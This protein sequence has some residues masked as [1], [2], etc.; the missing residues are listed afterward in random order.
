M[1]RDNAIPYLA[2]LLLLAAAA[3]LWLISGQPRMADGGLSGDEMS[4]AEKAFCL[5]VPLS[6]FGAMAVAMRRAYLAGSWFWLLACFFAW[7]VTFV[8]ALMVNRTNG[9]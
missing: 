9:R 1:T 3:Y 7:P 6:V 5:A 4:L 2:L 8:Y